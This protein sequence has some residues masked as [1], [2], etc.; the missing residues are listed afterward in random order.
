MTESERLIALSNQLHED[1]L[2]LES[3]KTYL[4]LKDALLLDQRL[5]KI[6][7]QRESLQ[8]SIRYLHGAEKEECLLTCKKL[9]LQYDEDPLVINYRCAY[10]HI[11]TLLEPISETRF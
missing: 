4:A 9:L 8:R 6:K 5:Q 7:E 11:C 1:F 10:G 2:S 3:V